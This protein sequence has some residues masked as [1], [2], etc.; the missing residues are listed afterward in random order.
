VT[1]ETW[2]QEFYPIKAEQAAEKG[3]VAAV[4]HS[5]VKWKGLRTKNLVKHGLVRGSGTIR[6]RSGCTDVD[7]EFYIDWSSCALCQ[8]HPKQC[9]TCPLAQH[10]RMSCDGSVRYEQHPNNHGLAPF[11]TYSIYGDPEPMIAA[12]EA[13]LNENH[14]R[15]PPEASA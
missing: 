13:T 15:L 9:A 2:K 5:L 11:S 4:E 6:E 1:L 10:L 3:D 12:L 8:M 14:S 7:Y